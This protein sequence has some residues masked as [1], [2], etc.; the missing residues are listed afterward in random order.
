MFELNKERCHEIGEK[1]RSLDLKPDAF[2]NLFPVPR[3]RGSSLVEYTQGHALVIFYTSA[4]CHQT[5]SLV[6]KINGQHL[7]GWNYLYKAFKRC[8]E[9]DPDLL[10]PN[11][12]EHLSTNMLRYIVSDKQKLNTS[13]LTQVEERVEL[14]RDAA[15][16][17]KQY[18]H[19]DPRTLY[20]EGRLNGEKGIYQRMNEYKAFSM[21]PTF[22]KK[23]TVFVMGMV[24]SLLWLE[25]LDPGNLKPMPDYHKER[26]ALRTGMVEVTDN[27]ILTKLKARQHQER[28][29]DDALRIETGNAFLKMVD[30]SR[31]DFFD[32]ELLAWA[33]ARN[34]CAD[35]TQCEYPKDS[36]GD[37]DKYSEPLTRSCPFE[38]V[39]TRRTTLWEPTVDTLLH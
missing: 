13:K 37:W 28:N 29:I 38:N 11:F 36:K 24:R 7:K 19:S 17:L 35:S 27:A 31:R 34:Y 16:R 5:K 12:M 10:H 2:Q 26:F 6:G 22:S 21:D 4:I 30:S 8:A 20:G 1:F 33:F 39:C 9:T 18:N 23:T 3:V 14:L 32:L 25:L 15:A